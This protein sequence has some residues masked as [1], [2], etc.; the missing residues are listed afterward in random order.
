MALRAGRHRAPRADRCR[1]S[2]SSTR[3][4]GSTRWSGARS[5]ASAT[6]FLLLA[7]RELWR[8]RSERSAVLAVVAALIKPQLAILVPIVAWSRS[9]A[10]SGRRA[11]GATRSAPAASGFGWERRTTGWL[12]ILTTAVAGLPDRR[13]DVGPVR[14][15]G[16]PIS[17]DGA[18]RR[19]SLLRLMFST[20]ATYPYVSVNAYNAWALFPVDGASMAD[21]GWPALRLALDSPGDGRRRPGR[22]SGRSRPALVGAVLLLAGSRSSSLVVVARRPDRLHDPGRAS[23]CLR[24]R[25]SP[26]RPAS[27]SATCSRCSALGRHP[28]RVLVALA[29]RLRC[30]PSIATFLNMYVV[31]DDALP[32]QP[33]AV[34]DWLGIGDR[35]PVLLGR[36]D[37]R[38]GQ[39]PAR[40]CGALA[41]LRPRAR[42]GPSWPSSSL[43]E[44]RRRRSG[45][46]DERRRTT[47]ARRRRTPPAGVAR[48][49]GSRS[50][51]RPAPPPSGPGSPRPGLVRPAVPG[52]ADA[53]R[54]GSAP[55]SARRRSAPTARRRST[56]RRAAASTGSTC[57]WS[58]SWWSRAL[59]LRT[60]RLAEPA[61]MHFDE[62]YH[63]RT[64]TEFLQ[65]WRYGISHNI[66]E[67]THPHL[68]KYVMAGG[69][70]RLRRARRRRRR[71][72]WACTVRRRGHRA[73]P[74]GPDPARRPCRRP[75]LGGDRQRA[76]SPTTS[77][78]ARSRRRWAI[79]GATAV[80]FDASD[81]QS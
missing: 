47:P 60:Y 7:V 58:S 22:R 57:G 59:F 25:S 35:D 71:A 4:P 24:W 69:H 16:G 50:R 41:Q 45:P 15:L 2:S 44:A 37:H 38:D 49:A 36:G 20:A 18:V 29:D 19:S 61:R 64:A 74:R 63:A 40:S 43:D 72:T 75:R 77:R 48:R 80:A 28:G 27:T 76:R 67:W 65:D 39:H 78:P 13:R 14:A 79:P 62:V 30:W 53:H 33:A 68:A 17:A 9:A 66:Y 3:S 56:A 70:R 55:G 21:N 8:G 10:R 34:S 23:A 12:R 6:V 51:C 81:P 52:G 73:A 54:A 5:T 1:R 31:L 46:D 42:R 26:S 11:A 32:G